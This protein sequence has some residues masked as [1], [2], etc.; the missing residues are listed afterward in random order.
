MRRDMERDVGRDLH[1]HRLPPSMITTHNISSNTKSDDHPFVSQAE[2]HEY[3]FFDEASSTRRTRKGT[4]WW[5]WWWSAMIEA[6]VCL[7]FISG[8]VTQG[9]SFTTLTLPQIRLDTPHPQQI[10]P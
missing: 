2:P 3:R 8:P 7:F 6:V 5:W 9:I 1:L 4:D 10:Q